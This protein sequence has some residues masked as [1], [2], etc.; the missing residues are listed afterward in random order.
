[1]K[2]LRRRQAEASGRS[3]EGDQP[4]D[5][6]GDDSDDDDPDDRPGAHDGAGDDD[7]DGS[8]GRPPLRTVP[9]AD[10]ADDP[11]RADDGSPATPPAGTRGGGS[12]GSGSGGR[13]G[14]R[15]SAGGPRDGAPSLRSRIGMVILILVVAFVVVMLAF[16]I[17]L[18][19]DAIWFKSVGYDQVFW[20]RVGVQVGLFLL[21]LVIALAILLG[22]LW[23]AGRLVPPSTG[24]GGTIKG[25]IDRLN[26]AAANADRSRQRGPW[27]PWGGRGGQGRGP[28]A[29]TPVDMPDLIPLGRIAIVVVIVLTALGVAGSIAGTWQTI[30]LWQHGVPFDPSGTV[31]PDPIFG[32]D[33]SFYLF[34]LPFLR[35]LQAEVSGLLVAALLVVGARYLLSA[36]G[37]SPV[38]N[39]RV[40]VH[41]GVLAALFLMVVALGYQ[42]DKL[43]LVHSTRGIAT[44]VSY[45]DQ[46][47]QFIAYDLLTAVSAITAALLLGGAFARVLWPV[48]ITVAFWFIASI[49]IGRVYPEIVQRITVVPNQ[50]TLEAPY[51]SNNIAMTRLAFN[52]GTWAE[53]PY[54][55]D[56]PLTQA[57]V[58]QDQ[59]TFDNARLWDYRPLGD[60]L[61]QLQT[62]RQ[63]YAFPDVDIDRY[64]FGTDLKQVMLSGREIALDKNPSATGWVNQ[65]LVYTHGMG[66]AMVRVSQVTSQG[67]PDLDISNLPPVSVNGAPQITEPRIYFGERPSGYVI[68]GA[69]QDEFDY[70]RGSSDSDV[71]TNRWSG[72]TGIPLDTTLTRLL[73]ALRFRD[74]DMLIS[75]QI[76]NQSQL[77]M[78]RTIQERVQDIAPFLRYD[79]D[80]YLVI[81]GSGRLK[82]VQDAYTMSD[83]FP[84]AQSFDPT[85]LG[86][87]GLGDEPF[88]YLRNS[89]KVVMDAYDGT[90]TFYVADSSD[91]IVRAWSGVFPTL[92][93]PL[94]DLPA[95]L[96]PHLRVPEELFNVQTRMFGRYHVVDPA[97]FYTN[98][99]LW[100]IPMGQ[101]NEQ[102]L[103]SEAYYVLMRMPGANKAEFLLL[104]PMIPSSRP[105]MIAWVAVRNDPGGY[106]QTTVFRFPSQSS[107]F[108]PAQVEAQ[109]DIDPEISAQ[110]TLWNQSGSTVIRGNLI[111]LP[112]GNSLIYLQ[113]VYLQSNSS[114]FPAFERI[115]VASSNHVVWAATLEDAL[116]K[117]LVEQGG[118]PGPSPS[119]T[120]TPTPGPSASPGASGTPGPVPS[121]D[122]SALISYANDHFDRAEA[123]LRAGDFATYGQEIELVRQALSQLEGLTGGVLPSG[124]PA[125][126][127]TPP[128][129]S[130]SPA[131]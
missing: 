43:D 30:L 45:T 24:E 33:I 71:V 74:F 106:G 15:G 131:P 122:V 62:I 103:P 105:N 53:Q 13:R 66:V 101:T 7:G 130:P 112:V 67:Q 116:N 20:T 79:K 115:V 107:V 100:T 46:H 104:Q 51:I 92:F 94:T 57:G 98:N 11:D 29:V 124:A 69:Q 109:I 102:S 97:T 128:A 76:T 89:V 75:N 120:P 64:Q 49:A 82:Y 77:L 3:A 114:K 10:D 126:P 91:P 60:A 84:N 38:F 129:P 87:T 9:P 35:F 123:A 117:F 50:Q 125:A 111:V 6:E 25:W 93:K 121:G 14:R 95:D 58:E 80:P 40:R 37:G 70:P 83:Q 119:P 52:L 28:V 73:F 55:G 61:N 12:R 36:V 22:N 118:G 18:W 1:M 68:V 2:E 32:R 26:E 59:D 85:D 54:A 4:D 90:T 16:G 56:Q 110:I 72:A 39:T 63:Y 96:Q 65:R 21:G 78:N 5:A 81:D 48:G 99:D 8:T 41:L 44:G 113:P 88:N 127:S 31:V 86:A 42:L 27:D 34:D 17:E 23:L 47:A 108:G 19:T